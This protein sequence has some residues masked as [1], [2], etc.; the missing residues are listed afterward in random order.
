MIAEDRTYPAD[1]PWRLENAPADE[2]T[3]WKA[4]RTVEDPE[5]PV[6]VVDLGLIY[7]V[8]ISAE[9]ATI[10]LTLTYSGCPARD[11]ICADVTDAVRDTDVVETVEVSLVYTPEWTPQ[12]ITE[13]GRNELT[14]FGLAVPT[15]PSDSM[16]K[17]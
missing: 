17:E 12:R 15:E 11:L 9:V 10:S 2:R 5:L 4:L 14:E 6:S 16:M 8:E 7:D 1:L 3:I 13:R